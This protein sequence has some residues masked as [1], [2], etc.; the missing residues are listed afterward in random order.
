MAVSSRS[1][2]LSVR[3]THSLMDEQEV[4]STLS[5]GESVPK[6]VK[7]YIAVLCFLR[8]AFIVFWYIFSKLFLVR[9]SFSGAKSSKSSWPRLNSDL[10]SSGIFFTMRSTYLRIGSVYETSWESLQ[11]FCRSK[12]CVCVCVCVRACMCVCVCVCR[13][14]GV[15]MI[16]KTVR[17]VWQARS[18]H[19]H[20]AQVDAQS[21]K[22]QASRCALCLCQLAPS[23]T[24]QSHTTVT[25]KDAG[26]GGSPGT[27]GCSLLPT[28]IWGWSETQSPLSPPILPPSSLS[29]SL[30]LT[31]FISVRVSA[32]SHMSEYSLAALK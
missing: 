32:A 3:S 25:Q 11:T 4:H 2:A 22:S 16:T 15:Y 18:A 21:N 23:N 7:T 20:C 27:L 9:T 1:K 24:I 5:Q 13:C 29:F 17:A 12:V 6:Q 10:M 14:A 30:C 8:T 26:E 19:V 28:Y 31:S